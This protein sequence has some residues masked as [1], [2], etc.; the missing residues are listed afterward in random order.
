MKFD[1]LWQAKMASWWLEFSDLQ[2]PDLSLEKKWETRAK[3]FRDLG[4][5]TVVMFGFIA[6]GIMFM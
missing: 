4:V 1:W 5:N 2:W 6:G 3:K